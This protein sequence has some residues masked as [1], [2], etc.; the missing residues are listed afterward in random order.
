[1]VQ[2]IVR[3]IVAYPVA[4]VIRKPQLLRFRIPVETDGVAHAQRD[5]LEHA[6]LRID[7]MDRSLHIGRHDDVAGRADVEIQLAVGAQREEFPEMAGLRRRIEVVDHDFRLGRIVEAVFNAIVARDAVPL[8][9]EQ[10][11]LAERD[12]VGRF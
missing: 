2:R 6:R 3:Q 8:G 5:S 7:T 12:A 11:A 1:V 10:R 4:R 9:D